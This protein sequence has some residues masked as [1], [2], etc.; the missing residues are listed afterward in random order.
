MTVEMIYMNISHLTF[1]YENTLIYED[2]TLELKKKD[3]IGI[4]GVNGAG[5]ST[6][7]KLILKQ[8]EPDYGSIKVSSNSRIYYLPQVITDELPNSNVTVL[9]YLI[10]ARP[11]QK[12]EKEMN[13]LYQKMAKEKNT[14]K[15][16]KRLEYIQ[17]QLD[18]W[19]Y[20]EAES[21][22][23]RLI[24][25]LNIT[26]ELLDQKLNSC[27]GGQKSKIA[28]TR[29]LYSKPEIILLDEPTNHLDEKSKE[30]IVTYLK[31]YP[32]MVLVISHDINFLNEVTSKTLWIDKSTKKMELINGNYEQFQK[33]KKIQ[34]K[35]LKNKYE[36]QEKEIK[37][38][39][40][41]VNLYSNSSG[42]RKRMAESREKSLNKLLKNRIEL[43][44]ISKKVNLKM[45]VDELGSLIPLKLEN[46]SF[47]YQKDNFLYENINFELY[48]QERFLII[49]ENGVGKSTLLKLIHQDLKPINGMIKLSD[50]TRIGYYAQEHEILNLEKTILEN[51]E[52]YGLNQTK[53][54]SHLGNFLFTD[55]DVYKKVK[56]L[57]PGER[58]RLAF[59][60]LTLTKA[61]LLLLDEPTNHLDP[62][63]Q[64]L[65]ATFLKNYSGS[66]ILVSHNPIFVDKLGIE[67]I[68]HLPSGEVFYYDRKIVE[69]YE[70]ENNNE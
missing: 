17:S 37:K 22:L 8:L 26:D 18:Y 39:Q 28:F 50:K 11:I 62:E 35:E 9:D 60:K 69:F 4:I 1:S 42:K 15:I 47:G 27:S 66:I 64:E 68:L 5:K 65:I 16:E 70:K 40:D 44:P 6:L 51:M 59:A 19:E 14:E 2:V 46:L 55:N 33:I 36:S 30:N 49:G 48:R 34:E 41:I 13:E 54:R 67:R 38:L 31:N 45:Q 21:I 63:T 53:I 29:L 12:L 3:H 10:S 43:H 23:L 56:V 61:N 24:S 20:Y 52:E 32:G 58:S 25:M 7:F 57:S